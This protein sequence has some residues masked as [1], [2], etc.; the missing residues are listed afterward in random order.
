[1]RDETFLEYRAS[2]NFTKLVMETRVEWRR[3]AAMILRS[4]GAPPSIDE[5]D[6]M[7][8]MLVECARHALMW[9]PTKGPSLRT[10]VVWR[11]AETAKKFVHRERRS[12][13]LHPDKPR[14]GPPRYDICFSSLVSERTPSSEYETTVERIMPSAPAHQERDVARNDLIDE[15]CSKYGFASIATA[16]KKTRAKIA[17]TIQE[18]L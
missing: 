18:H 5:D 11:A 13:R 9:D 15:I 1:M 17:Q 2:G 8:V 7:Q 10:H 16:D 3:L 12:G 6:V 4:L 14:S